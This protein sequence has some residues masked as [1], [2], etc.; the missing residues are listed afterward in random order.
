[1][2]HPDAVNWRG[3]HAPHRSCWVLTSYQ[4]VATA[5]KNPH[6]APPG[7]GGGGGSGG[8]AWVR[9]AEAKPKGGRG[10]FGVN[11]DLVD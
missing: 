3:T 5:P 6:R 10:W 1:M 2:D 7:G 8:T 4:V 9:A 11:E